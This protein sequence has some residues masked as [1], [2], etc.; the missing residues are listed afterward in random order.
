M[1]STSLNGAARAA[2]APRKSLAQQLDRMDQMLDG[3][4][5]GLSAAV[6][7]AVKDAVGLAV[8][9]ALREV[10]THPGVVARLALATPH[11]GHPAPA[12][13]RI[14][15]RPS[16]ACRLWGTSGAGAA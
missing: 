7:D 5:D 2:G 14:A 10:L 4:S 15:V 1:T 3:L 9:A 8:Q 11:V 12:P 13:G 6:V 16:W